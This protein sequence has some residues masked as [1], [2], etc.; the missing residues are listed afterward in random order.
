MPL[1]HIQPKDLPQVWDIV[2]PMLQ[3]AI[4]IDPSVVTIEQVEYSVR[5]GKNFLLV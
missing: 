2:A 5:T 1:Y 3:R 4:D